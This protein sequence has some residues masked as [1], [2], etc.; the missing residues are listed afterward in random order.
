MAQAKRDANFVPTLIGVSSV[1]GTTPTLIKVNPT[2]GAML[3]DGTSLYS[4]FSATAPI[5]FSAGVIASN[6]ASANTANY[7]V[8]RDASGNF[9][10]G[11]ITASLTGAAS[12]NVLKAGDTMTGALIVSPSITDP[13]L[14]GGTATTSTLTLRSTS[15]VGTTGADIIFQTGNNGATEAMRILNSGRVGIGVATPLYKLDLRDGSAAA[16]S[17]ALVIN[18]TMAFGGVPGAQAAFLS[19]NMYYDG[20]NDLRINTGAVAA[21]LLIR[22]DNTLNNVNGDLFNFQFVAA[23]ANPIT[24]TSLMNLTR[25]GNVGI[26]TFNPGA[27][28]DVRG[29]AIFNEDGADVDFRIEGD[30][31]PN[32]FFVDASADNIKIAGIAA[33]AT[34]EGTNHLDIFDGTAPVGTLANGISLYSTSGELRVMD[35]AGNATLLSPH[36][37]DGSWI[38]DSFSPT[39]GKHL[40]VDMERMVKFLNKHF[41]QDWVKEVA[42]QQ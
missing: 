34:T 20:T 42:W 26:G 11:T 6:S 25:A 32:L 24:W 37:K 17:A 8:Q 22:N 12:L 38:Y 7:L 28:L 4:A 21:R 23:G 2:T 13:L 29:S 39:T 14:I 33:R 9:S 35:S 19:Q 27:K 41:G 5:T 1:D 18:N 3:I 40:R 15:G 16:G 36:A 31:Q 30:T 10:A